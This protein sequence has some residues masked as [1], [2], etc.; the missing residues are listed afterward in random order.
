MS[1]PFDGTPL[2]DW[3]ACGQNLTNCN[4]SQLVVVGEYHDRTLQALAPALNAASANGAFITSCLVHCQL[5]QAW[6]TGAVFNGIDIATVV[7]NWYTGAAKGADVKLVMTTNY[8]SR[9]TPGM[10]RPG[11]IDTW[12]YIGPSHRNT[13]ERIVRA[14]IAE[15]ELSPEV[16]FD[17]L[18]NVIEGFTPAYI[19]EVLNKAI[20]GAVVLSEDNTITVTTDD[21]L[22]AAKLVASK[23]EG[24]RLVAQNGVRLNDAPVS[25]P[26][27]SVTR[28]D[29]RDGAAKISLGRKKHVLVRAAG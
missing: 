16:D 17:A 18:W 23:G 25:D 5:D 13:M 26:M 14:N 28:A 1:A 8:M 11:R 6:T 2:P 12:L 21:L 24:R 9:I 20:I 22:A 15:A 3:T 4:A 19:H 27:Q 29:L 10:F 7:G